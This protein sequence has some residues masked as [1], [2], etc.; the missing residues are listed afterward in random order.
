MPRGGKKIPARKPKIAKKSDEE[1]RYIDQALSAFDAASKQYAQFRK[2]QCEVPAKLAFGGNA[3]D[4]RRLLCQIELDARRM[5]DLAR[6]T[7][8]IGGTH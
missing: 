4:D 1:A 6:D 8:S 7:K 5:A 3:A 2:T